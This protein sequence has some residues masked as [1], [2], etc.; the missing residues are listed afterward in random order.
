M[1][2]LDKTWSAQACEL[3]ALMRALRL[4]KNKKG[5]TYTNSKYAFGVVHTFGKIWEER[6]L[7]NAQGKGLIHEALIKETLS[8]LRGPTEI[9]VVH[10]KGHQKGT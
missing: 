9:A 2:P 8:A 7:I 10:I 5:T 3:Y 1:G 4:L 6:G